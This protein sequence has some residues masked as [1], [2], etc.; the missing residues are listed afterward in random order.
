MVAAING[1]AIAGECILACACDD[2][3][4][5]RGSGRIGVPELQVGVPFP[6]VPAE[7][8]RHALG[9]ARAQRAML[10]GNVVVAERAVEE[11][12][13]D[14]LVAPEELMPRA[15]AVARAM[16]GT[17]AES[18]ARTKRDLRRPV[19][20]TWN[21]LAET[22]DRETLEAWDSPAVREAIRAFVEKTLK[23]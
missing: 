8:A 17:P 6:I 20:E 15:V 10:V 7:I 22:H 9:T 13:A 23:K 12:F 16:A 1:H 3:L 18:Y 4:M 19:I 5:A 21:R 11:G 2:R 14:E